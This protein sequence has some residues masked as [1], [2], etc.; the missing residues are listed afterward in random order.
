[1]G[2][3]TI[4]ASGLVYLDASPIIYSVEKIEPFVEVLQ[5]VW[6]AAHEGKITIFGSELLLL[7][8][9][10]KPIQMGDVILETSFR[11]LL[12]ASREYR[13]VPIS[14]EVIELAIRIR[15]D[16]KL[17]TPD[18]IH[19]ATALANGCSLFITNDPVFQRIKG[20]NVALLSEVDV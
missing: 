13:L 19:A 4:P 17:K 9:L 7:E 8:T 3:L 15:A 2:K 16:D 10:V 12:L 18:A 11:N 1:M 20:L 14:L 5:P 6:F